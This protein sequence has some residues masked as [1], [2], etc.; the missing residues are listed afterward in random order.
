MPK[1]I[2]VGTKRRSTRRKPYRKRKPTVTT[3]RIRRIAKGEA[4]RVAESK[5]FVILNETY[6]LITTSARDHQYAYRNV[7]A[8]LAAGTS[9]FQ[10]IGNEFWP[11]LLKLKWRFSVDWRT[12]FTLNDSSRGCQSVIFHIWVIATPDVLT[13]GTT[14]VLYDE[15]S[16]GPLWFYQHEPFKATMNGNNVRVMKHMQR[17]FT[18]EAML[19]DDTGTGATPVI[20]GTAT[21][22]G[23][24][25][26]RFKGKRTYEDTLA[27]TSG[28]PT[29]QQYLKNIN[30]YIVS[31]W[32]AIN[33]T[34]GSVTPGFG[35]ILIDSY[36]YFKDP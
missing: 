36:L 31:G 6:S 24:M 14:P 22:A 13:P 1:Y 20:W 15:T 11:R 30:Y 3:K 4:L 12:V 9:S 8:P 33:G 25:K 5:R 28:G 32:G 19:Q 35:N 26:V 21:K 16:S 10:V 34:V 18:P 27:P 7:F 17:T 29:R 23:T 2:R